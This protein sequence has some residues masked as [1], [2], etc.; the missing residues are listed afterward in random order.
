M[1]LTRRPPSWIRGIT[2]TEALGR[3]AHG[4]GGT[5]CLVTAGEAETHPVAGLQHLLQDILLSRHISAALWPLLGSVWGSISTSAGDP[6]SREVLLLLALHAAT[7]VT[8]AV[9]FLI[10]RVHNR[11]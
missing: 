2:R 3:N 5:G 4:E 6:W 7:A 1:T 8:G 9:L 10:R 11:K